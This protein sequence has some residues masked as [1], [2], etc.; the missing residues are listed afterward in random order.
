MASAGKEC[1]PSGTCTQQGV[2]SSGSANICY[3]NGVK[4]II[5]VDG[6]F[7]ASVTV[8]NG[9]TTCFTMA[10]SVVPLISGGAITLTLKSGTGTVIGTV[11]ADVTANQLSVTC[12]GGQP[13]MLDPSC[14]GGL[15]AASAC[16]QG[17]CTP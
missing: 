16:T 4:E 15:S 13:V 12:T 5:G 9:G 7:M 17:V 6:T 8:K 10:G 11:T 1:L 14:I 3:P 2:I